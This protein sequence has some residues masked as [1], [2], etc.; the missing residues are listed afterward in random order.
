M[1]KLIET[2]EA[3]FDMDV[4]DD[5]PVLVDF[6]APWCAPCKMLTPHLERLAEDFAGQLKVLKLNIDETTDGW[7]KYGVRAIPTLVLYANGKEYDRLSG[8]STNRLRVMMEK[9]FEGLG[10]ALP[11]PTPTEIVSTRAEGILLKTWCSFDGDKTVKAAA[12]ERLH[13]DVQEERYQPSVRIAGEQQTFETTVGAPAALG[14]LIDMLF[15]GLGDN[16]GEATADAHA[17]LFDLVE[18]MPVGVDLG[19]VTSDTLYEL[20]HESPWAVAPYFA[21]GVKGDLIARIRTLHER[22]RAREAVASADWELLRREVILSAG[23]EFDDETSRTIE[24]LSEPLCN[25][26]VQMI[27]RLVF[28]LA[29]NDSSR[30]PDWS[31]SD[32]RKTGEIM[33]EDHAQIVRALGGVPNF[34]DAAWM[35]AYS[36]RMKARHLE[37]CSEEPELWSRHDAWAMYLEKTRHEIAMHMSAVLRSHVLSAAR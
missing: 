30:F 34:Q 24:V 14:E 37:R 23:A 12:I 35:T 36:E 26:S 2:T 22:E 6:W 9:W 13:Q 25:G 18:A 21:G 11:V 17:W 32:K 1:T 19:M 29:Q 3:T 16:K 4:R 5:I 28:S 31:E 33:S 15:A 7:T 10:L 8:P 20:I 27:I